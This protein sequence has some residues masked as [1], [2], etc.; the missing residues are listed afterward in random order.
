M[1]LV[2]PHIYALKM[3]T[4][5]T[6]HPDINVKC[7]PHGGGRR[8]SHGITFHQSSSSGDRKHLQMRCEIFNSGTKGTD[9]NTDTA[10]HKATLLVWLNMLIHFLNNT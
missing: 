5:I 1:S 10:I 4:E 3:A 7:Q 6:E 9:Q 2:F 8:Q